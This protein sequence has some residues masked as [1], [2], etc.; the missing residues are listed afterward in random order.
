MALKA[1]LMLITL[2]PYVTLI[3]PERTFLHGLQTSCVSQVESQAT[4]TGIPGRLF[5]CA[6]NP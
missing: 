5:A 6:R 1:G 4:E 2:N 3:E